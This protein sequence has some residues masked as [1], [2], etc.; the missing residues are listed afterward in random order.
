MK[1]MIMTNQNEHS[2]PETNTENNRFSHHNYGGGFRRGRSGLDWATTPGFHPGKVAAVVLGAA[3][4]P[5]LGIAALG[6][7]LWNSRR[8]ANADGPNSFAQGGRCGHRGMGGRMGRRGM[9]SSGNSAMDDHTS[10]VL[11]ELRETRHE[12]AEHRAADTAKRDAEAFAQ[13]QAARETKPNSE[14]GS[15]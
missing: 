13:F 9:R 2:N 6:Y 11:N 4:F 1:G 5:P 8:Y 12:F 15:A 14:T 3:L 10:K 7:F